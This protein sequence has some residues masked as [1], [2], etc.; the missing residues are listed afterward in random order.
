MLFSALRRVN[1]RENARRLQGRLL[2]VQ[3]LLEAI[4]CGSEDLS[5]FKH[6]AADLHLL[7]WDLWYMLWGEWWSG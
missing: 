3:G 5:A 6:R 1:I 2:V 4:V 7:L